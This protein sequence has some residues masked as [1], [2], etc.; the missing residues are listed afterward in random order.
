[1][2]EC[3]GGLEDSGQ[4]GPAP[5]RYLSGRYR[6]FESGDNATGG[7]GSGDGDGES[8]GAELGVMGVHS[9]PDQLQAPSGDT[10]PAANCSSWPS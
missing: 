4:L 6:Q 2:A 3:T 7:G 10:V 5:T 8:I 1:M 9:E